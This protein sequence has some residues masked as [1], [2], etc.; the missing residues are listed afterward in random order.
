MEL[1]QQPV[2]IPQLD[3]IQLLS[4]CPAPSMKKV[5][6]LVSLVSKTDA[7]T[8]M[9]SGETGVGKEIVAESIHAQSERNGKPFITVQCNNQ[10]R[11]LMASELFGHDRGAFTGALKDHEGFFEV[12]DGGTI[13]LDEIGELPL[14]FQSRL[15]RIIQEKKYNRVGS[16][17]TRATDIRVIAASNQDLS[18]LTH[19]GKFRRDLF[20]RL[21]VF[22]IHVPSLRER[23]MDIQPLT[24]LFVEMFGGD[25]KSVSPESHARLASH[26]WPGNVRELKNVI[27]RALILNGNKDQLDP[28]HIVFDSVEEG[29]CHQLGKDLFKDLA[30]LR[31][32]KP[33]KE[34][35]NL[36]EKAVLE[37]ALAH[38]AK[39]GR[40][41]NVELLSKTLKIG[42][43]MLYH[44]LSK[45]KLN[46]YKGKTYGE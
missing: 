14:D 9:I 37:Q 28:E 10:N 6:N 33:L 36:L 46:G 19:E 3:S 11:E 38:S 15:L 32:N 43:Q 35:L 22:P 40:R 25:K 27:E 13:F 34:T 8:V 29:T 39:P 42:R 16:T 7:T 5:L 23:Q 4:L 20:Y 2:Q 31:Q 41:P 24:Q 17:K 30:W 1:T 12:A 18:K 44:R 26:S 45:H 21:N